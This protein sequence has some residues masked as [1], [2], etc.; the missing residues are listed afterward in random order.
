MNHKRFE[1][2]KDIVDRYTRCANCHSDFM[3]E[4]KVAL[5][6]DMSLRE[7]HESVGDVRNILIEL[8]DNELK[9]VTKQ[10]LDDIDESDMEFD[11]FSGHT[12]IGK[13]Y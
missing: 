12:V 8:S 9:L 13:V 4:V 6:A 5:Y 2:I 10:E 11:G 3:E 1:N 7:M